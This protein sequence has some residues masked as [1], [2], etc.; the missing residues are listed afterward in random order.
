[1]TIS[2]V[3]GAAVHGIP[4]KEVSVRG[5]RGEV[6]AAQPVGLTCGGAIYDVVTT[7]INPC[8]PSQ[9]VI[10]YRITLAEIVVYIWYLMT[11]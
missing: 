7:V 10:M 8:G 4:S 2:W 6:W 5:S 9:H 3:G 11:I 1:M